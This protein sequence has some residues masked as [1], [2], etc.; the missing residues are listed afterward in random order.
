M[1]GLPNGIRKFLARE[2]F[3]VDDAIQVLWRK[4]RNKCKVIAVHLFEFCTNRIKVRQRR[5][6]VKTGGGASLHALIPY[7]FRSVKVHDCVAHGAKTRT[8]IARELFICE[9][10]ARVKYPPVRPLVVL[11]QQT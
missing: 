5:A 6:I 2:T 11:E 3:V 4:P 9:S 10:R 1:Q 8:Q 7:P